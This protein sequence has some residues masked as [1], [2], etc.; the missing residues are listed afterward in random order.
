MVG[1][2]A[3]EKSFPRAAITNAT[4]ATVTAAQQAM[5]ARRAVS[6]RRSSFRYNASEPATNE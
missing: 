6:P 4:D 2:K 1:C 5:P 3:T